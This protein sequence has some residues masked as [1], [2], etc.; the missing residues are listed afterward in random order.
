MKIS[1]TNAHERIADKLA[2]FEQIQRKDD[3]YDEEIVY[4]EMSEEDFD[5]IV[6]EIL[7]ESTKDFKQALL[8]YTKKLKIAWLGKADGARIST[9]NYNYA[10]VKFIK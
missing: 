2:K 8:R 9:Y 6:L 3:L 10:F 1:Y 7:E 4:Y 5:K